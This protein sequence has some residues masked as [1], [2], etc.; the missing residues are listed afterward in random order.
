MY[1]TKRLLGLTAGNICL[2][3]IQEQGVSR[4][5]VRI[6]Q[7]FIHL[8]RV[9]FGLQTAPAGIQGE[10]CSLHYAVDSFWFLKA[11]VVAQCRW[12]SLQW[13]LSSG[14]PCLINILLIEL[15]GGPSVASQKEW[16]RS[17]CV[18]LR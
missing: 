1:G 8:T 4:Q 12:H 9:Y 13:I 7:R 10:V 6:L 2:A 14:R 18:G 3:S 17:G 5:I 16:K 15:G 11:G